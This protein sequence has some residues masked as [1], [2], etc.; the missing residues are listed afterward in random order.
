MIAAVDIGGTKTLI[1][2]FDG[3]KITEQIKFPTPKEYAD[4]QIELANNVAKL[5]TKEFSS[6]VSAVPGL[7]NRETGVAK[8]FGNLSWTNIPIGDDL[9]SIFGQPVYIENDSKLAALSEGV[10]RYPGFRKC[11]YVTISTGIS[12]GLVIDGKLDPNFLDI[13][14]GQMLFEYNGKLTDWEDFGSGR[15]FQEKFGH[16]VSDT[17]EDDE[18]A[19]YWFAHNIAIGLVNLTATLDPDII[20]LGGGA[21]AELDSFRHRLDEQLRLYQNPMLTTPPI[22][23]ATRPNDAVVYGCYEYA[24]NI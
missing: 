19:W 14:L 20:V 15:A 7:L 23:K 22:E 6:V 17:K 18:K 9:S 12:G 13:E 4:F 21:G 24:K 5:S 3:D 11:L 10:L 1:A 2:V 16:K 8:A